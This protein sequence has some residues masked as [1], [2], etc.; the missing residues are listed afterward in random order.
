MPSKA[1]NFI[2]RSATSLEAGGADL[3]A[4]KTS[5]PL[6]DWAG[7][8]A[9]VLLADPGGGKTCAFQ[10]EA[11]ECGGVYVTASHFAGDGAPPGW[12]NNKPLFIDALDELRADS[13]DSKTPLSQ[14]KTKLKELNNPPFRLACREADWRAA[15]DSEALQTLVPKSQTLQVLHLDPLSDEDITALL[16]N[17]GV[18]D[19]EDFISQAL[20]R[21]L[22]ELLRNPLLL[23]M[24]ADVVKGA[25]AWPRSRA[26]L[27]DQACRKMASEHNEIHREVKTVRPQQE[28]LNEAG[29]LC[30]CQSSHAG[31][32]WLMKTRVI[33]LHWPVCPRVCRSGTKTPWPQRWLPSSSPAKAEAAGHVTAALPNTWPPK[34]WEPTSMN[35]NC[36]CRVCAH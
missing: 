14:V 13:S 12:Q 25:G 9:Y 16:Q 4:H 17:Q 11:E 33:E 27:Y 36:P 30:C 21:D 20:Q 34:C 18:H 10:R 2:P 32:C 35:A 8:H 31:M 24:L 26:D 6:S 7:T 28:V 29:W 3:A 15:P 1:A 22:N 5:K 19:P 23:N